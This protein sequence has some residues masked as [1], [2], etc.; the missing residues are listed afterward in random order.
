[1]DFE[2]L[3]LTDLIEKFQK[4]VEEI[5]AT[6]S[7]KTYNG[8]G[9]KLQSVYNFLLSSQSAFEEEQEL[10]KNLFSS[11]N[12]GAVIVNN[13]LKT[14]ALTPEDNELLSECLEIMLTCCTKIVNMFKK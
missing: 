14:G 9:Q 12:Y 10:L 1:M 8:A 6:R 13:A 5:S 11:F 7:L 4:D 3:R 2:H